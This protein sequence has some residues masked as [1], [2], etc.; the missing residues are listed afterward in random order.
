[1]MILVAGVAPGNVTDNRLHYPPV[2]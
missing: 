2:T 1:M